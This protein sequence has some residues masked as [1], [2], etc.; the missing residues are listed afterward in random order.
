[1]GPP[2]VD[3]GLNVEVLGIAASQAQQLGAQPV[4]AFAFVAPGLK[5]D[6]GAGMTEAERVPGRGQ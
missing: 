3:R 4:G 2:F 1:M 6:A 5:A